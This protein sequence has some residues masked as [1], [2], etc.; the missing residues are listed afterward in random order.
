MALD[1]RGARRRVE[2]VQPAE[3][4]EVGRRRQL[5]VQARRLGQDPDPG[6][7]RLGLVDDIEPVDAGV[8]LAR[9]DERGQHPDRRRLARA[10]RAEEAQDLAPEHVEIHPADRPEVP[11]SP[12]ETGRVEHDGIG[13][14]HRTQS[15]RACHNRLVTGPWNLPEVTGIGRLPMHSVAH[16]DSLP[17][18]GRWRFQLLRSP[19]ADVGED[20]GE[21]QVPSVWTM[22]GTWDR[23]HYTNVQMPFDD[24]PPTVPELNPTGVYERDVRGAR[25]LGEPAR[26]APRRRRGERPH[27]RAQRRGGRGRQGRAPRLR[28]RPDRSAPAGLEHASV[29]RREVVRRDLRRGPG[30]VVAR[31]DHPV[32][33]P[34]RDRARSTSPTSGSRP[35]SPTT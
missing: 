29:A 34:V 9:R 1:P 12:A 31:R 27:R 2:A 5:V 23:P 3:E 22:S 19:D 15:D 25:R 33:V 10:V 6:A 24:L 26:R 4:L 14:R 30:R 13:R 7:D 16:R 11:E 32:G 18:D 20:W 17:L 35:V 21:A 28:V 8:S